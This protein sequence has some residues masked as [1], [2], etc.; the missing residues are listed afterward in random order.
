[1]HI[2]AGERRGTQ[3]FAPKGM[4]TRPTQA[5]VKES[6]FNIIQMYVPEANVLYLF[7]GS[8]NL[9]LVGHQEWQWWQRTIT[10]WYTMTSKN[11]WVQEE[12]SNYHNAL[13]IEP[14]DDGKA[15]IY[16]AQYI[17][18]PLVRQP[19][20]Y[21]YLNNGTHP[22]PTNHREWSAHVTFWKQ[23]TVEETTPLPDDWTI[24]NSPAGDLTVT[25][26]VKGT[27]AQK[28]QAFTFVVKLDDTEISG[29]F[30]DMTFSNGI[31]MFTLKDGESIT[32]EDL[33]AGVGYEVIEAA[34]PDYTAEI[35]GDKG[36]IE[37]KADATTAFTNTFKEE[38]QPV[39]PAAE[40]KGGT[41]K[42]GDHTAMFLVLLALLVSGGL[43]TLTAKRSR[44]H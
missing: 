28:K 5:K 12:M 24:T 4:D 22:D 15:M 37:A 8:G 3:L 25:K 17:D 42:T 44:Q 13:T 1:M 21:L 7:A 32:A 6:L 18:N 20:Q 27:D 38:P 16:A 26:T 29:E 19:E 11:G 36:T 10:Y 14:E 23:V 9:A 2:I 31:A 34:G 41:P 43:M 33:P 39:P 30:G 35:T 40:G